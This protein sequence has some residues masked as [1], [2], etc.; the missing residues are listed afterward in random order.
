MVLQTVLKLSRIFFRG[1]R[2]KF[3]IEPSKRVLENVRTLWRT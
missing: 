3:L 1:S 2:E